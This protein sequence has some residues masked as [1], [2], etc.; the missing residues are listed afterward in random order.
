[1]AMCGTKKQIAIELYKV[2][3][4]YEQNARAPQ[5]SARGKFLPKISQRI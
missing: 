2:T 4:Y 1:M 3:G 5:K